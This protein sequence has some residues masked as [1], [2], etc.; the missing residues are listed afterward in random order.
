M[1]EILTKV[2]VLPSGAVSVGYAVGRVYGAVMFDKFGRYEDAT[3]C[4][5]STKGRGF[6]EQSELPPGVLAAARAARI[7][8]LAKERAS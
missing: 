4:T 1:A 2:N 8:A 7:A 5:Q 6:C 3:R